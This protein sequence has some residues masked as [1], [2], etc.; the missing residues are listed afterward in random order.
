MKGTKS[1]AR[2]DLGGVAPEDRLLATKPYSPSALT[3]LV[4][5]PR[6]TKR[7]NKGVS[8]NLT[9]LCAPARFGKSTL[10]GEWVLQG[11]LPVGWLSLD[12]GDNDPTRFLSYAIAAL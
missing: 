11:K 7:L 6:L 12:E 2:T 1:L 10:L 9:L 3:N 8:G 5:R 4:T